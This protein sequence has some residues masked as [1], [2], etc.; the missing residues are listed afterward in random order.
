MWAKPILLW[1]TGMGP[2]MA[3]WAHTGQYFILH[4]FS[5][6]SSK[7][8]QKAEA[9]IQRSGFIGRQVYNEFCPWRRNNLFIYALQVRLPKQQQE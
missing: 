1:L 6:Y 5:E 9:N 8:A 4:I 3:L 7:V 2:R